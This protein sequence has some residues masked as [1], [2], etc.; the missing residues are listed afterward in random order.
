MRLTWKKDWTLLIILFLVMRLLYSAIGLAVALSPSPVPE[1]SGAEYD[2]TVPLLHTDA[3]S[4]QFV[5]VWYR[6]D[7]GWYLQIAAFGYTSGSGNI[8]FMPLYSWLIRGLASLMGN[9]LLSALIISNLAALIVFFLLYEAA[10]REGME[11]GTSMRVVLFFALFPTAF[12]LFAAY[13]ESIFIALVL[14]F[15]LAARR[16][17]W[18]LAGLLGGL[19]ALCRIQGVILCAV[20]AWLWLASLTENGNSNASPLEKARQVVGLL[21]NRSGWRTILAARQ[22]P[23]W[24]GILFPALTLAGFTLGLR[25]LNLNSMTDTFNS[26]WDIRPVMPWTGVALFFKRLFT[27]HLIFIDF[28]DLSFLVIMLALWVIG[29]RRLD[30]ALSLYSFLTIAV[31]FMRGTPPTLLMSFSRY[32]LVLFPAFFILGTIHNRSV[33]T[34]IWIFSFCLQM[35]MLF[36]FLQWRFIA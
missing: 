8:A 25:L 19:A 24:L 26:Y 21:T 34:G 12:F 6:W 20:L 10:S 18:L 14:G 27:T 17:A 31:L 15:W 29:L 1:A 3:I 32:L 2:T 4:Q 16:K 13:T 5:N 36:G 22:A 9:Y 30:P 28:L 23:A 11:T 33:R 35:V 7:T